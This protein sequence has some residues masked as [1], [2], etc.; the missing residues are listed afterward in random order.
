MNNIQN[1]ENKASKIIRDLAAHKEYLQLEIEEIEDELEV[2]KDQLTVVLRIN[3]KLKA[4]N[5]LL[6][7]EL[8]YYQDRCA[9]LECGGY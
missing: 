6:S 4:E 2:K 1:I 9:E 8:E 3:D 7:S 5:K